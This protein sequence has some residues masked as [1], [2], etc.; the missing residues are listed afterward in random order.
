MEL[1]EM[2][3]MWQ[4]MD[5]VLKQNKLM[6]ETVVRKMIE[7]RSKNALNK[8][9]NWEYLNIIVAAL[10]LMF[11]LVMMHRVN[12]T[13]AMLLSYFISL[14]CIIGSLIGGLYNIKKM[15]AIDFSAHSVTDAN[16]RVQQFRLL[17]SKE[18]IASFIIGPVMIAAMIVVMFKWVH[19]I[20][21]LGH[22]N[23]YVHHIIIGSVAY[24]FCAY[25]VYRRLY[26]NN[27]N[28][29]QDSLNEINVFKE[30]L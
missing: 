16:E 1:N 3:D 13:P 27:I 10:V 11:F 20:D 23:F 9:M 21:I 24:L 22:T 12:N 18:K 8:I 7:H 15:S 19:N 28:T 14:A 2:K 25:M 5:A 4:K 30:E 26:F 6:N 29:I 17:V